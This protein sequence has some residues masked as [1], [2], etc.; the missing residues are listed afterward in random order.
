MSVVH[1]E[2]RSVSDTTAGIAKLDEF[3]CQKSKI[4]VHVQ[5]SRDCYFLLG[6][7]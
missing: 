5:I 7:W 1:L 6:K 4:F 3:G 2:V